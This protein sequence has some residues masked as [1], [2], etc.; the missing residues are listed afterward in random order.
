MFQYVQ[1]QLRSSWSVY[2]RKVKDKNS[3]S[4]IFFNSTVFLTETLSKKRFEC[5]NREIWQKH[6]KSNN[7]QHSFPTRSIYTD[8]VAQMNVL[9]TKSTW[10]FRLDQNGI[11]PGADCENDHQVLMLNIEL[12]INKTQFEATR[13]I[14]L[15]HTPK[16][17]DSHHDG[18]IVGIAKVFFTSDATNRKPW[19]TDN[20]NTIQRR[21]KY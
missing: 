10:L 1:L 12:H 20:W 9:K 16:L 14:M 18:Q 19:I 17:R 5:Q 6:R 2:Q 7:Y 11:Y 13:N 8:C 15:L 4:F 21:I 3:K